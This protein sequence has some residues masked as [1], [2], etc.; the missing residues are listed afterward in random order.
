MAAQY[1]NITREEMESFLLPRGFR[2]IFKPGTAELLYGR[3]LDFQDGK[4]I[5]GM[6]ALSLVVFTGINPDGNSRTV[7]A[8]AIRVAILFRDEKQNGILPE[9]I[10]IGKSKRVHRVKGWR[11]N[12][13]DRLQNWQDLMGPKCP[14]CGFPTRLVEPKRGQHWK[15]FYGCVRNRRTGCRGSVNATQKT[16]V[17]NS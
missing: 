13:N 17:G 3:R 6:P 12:L 11:E 10:G 14:I 1:H 4:K 15:A 8:D 16:L 7:G 2:Q 5:A 9:P